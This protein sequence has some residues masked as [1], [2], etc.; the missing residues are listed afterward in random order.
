MRFRIALPW[1]AAL[2]LCILTLLISFATYYGSGS[3]YFSLLILLAPSFV[4]LDFPEALSVAFIAFISGIIYFRSESA[5]FSYFCLIIPVA[6]YIL[7]SQVKALPDISHEVELLYYTA[8][9][10]GVALFL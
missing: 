3:I 10:A 2:A 6:L 8:A 9:I 4:F 1:L 7:G 5:I